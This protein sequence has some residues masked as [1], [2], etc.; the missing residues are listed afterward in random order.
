[1]KCCNCKH[2]ER[3][4]E[5]GQPYDWREKVIDSPHIDRERDCKHYEAATRADKV[6]AMS[7]EE[8]ASFIAGLRIDELTAVDANIRAE[9]KKFALKWLQELAET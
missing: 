2:I 9:Y 5:D 8:L 4:Y 1:M 6:R 3:R 7:D